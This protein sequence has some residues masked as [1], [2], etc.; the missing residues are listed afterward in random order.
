[1]DHT[2]TALERAFQLAKSGD[3]ATVSDIRKR[4]A[5]EGYSIAQITG[6]AL[7]KQLLALIRAGRRATSSS[8]PAAGRTRS[9]C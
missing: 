2:I 7:S 9:G 6:G 3:Y 8:G 1:M 5:Q 4:L